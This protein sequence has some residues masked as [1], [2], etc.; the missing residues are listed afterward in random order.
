M[1]PYQFNKKLINLAKFELFIKLIQ[2]IV[3]SPSFWF[4]EIYN[5]KIV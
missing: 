3:L 1:K 4:T 5:K 2:E